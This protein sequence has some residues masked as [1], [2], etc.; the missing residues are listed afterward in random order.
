MIKNIFAGIKSY[1]I[2]RKIFFIVVFLLLLV[3][4]T[5]GP[6]GVPVRC[7]FPPPSAWNSGVG[8]QGAMAQQKPLPEPTKCYSPLHKE[9]WQH[10][11][12]PMTLEPIDDY[13]KYQYHPNP[14]STYQI[15][16]VYPADY[17]NDAILMGASHNVFVGKVIAMVG[18]NDFV[19]NPATQFS[20][21][22]IENIKGDLKDTVV[23]NQSG[24]YRNGALYLM[25]ENG[26]LMIPG[27]TY[28][29]STRYDPE[30]NYYTLNPHEN[31]SKLLTNDANLN[32]ATLQSLAA[33]DSKVE[34]LEAAYPNE[35]LLDADVAH[36]NTRNYY[37][38]LPPEEKAAAQSRADAAKASL[39]ASAKAQ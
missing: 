30:G 9:F 11:E 4:V 13:I 2:R 6:L 25:E 35:Q 19:G 12:W 16:L 17:S 39:D 24:G 21:E 36:A 28:L 14:G 15:H 10:P 33:Q 38:S 27:D 20:V 7:L 34:S 3:L 1:I 29:L 26:A 18:N 5:W 23:V 32:D 37:K 22:V 8:F 31:A